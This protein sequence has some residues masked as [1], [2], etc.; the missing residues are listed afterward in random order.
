V[1][2]DGEAVE[3]SEEADSDGVDDSGEH[4]ETQ[5]DT[6]D[7]GRR[8]LEAMEYSESGDCRRKRVSSFG[9]VNEEKDALR[10]AFP[11]TIPVVT[12]A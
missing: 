2:E 5:V 6:D 8:R 4:E 12:A 9:E 7:L 10:L 3:V 11:K 1:E